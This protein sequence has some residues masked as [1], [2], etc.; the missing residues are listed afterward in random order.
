MP[1]KKRTVILDMKLTATLELVTY[2]TNTSL[3][4]IK[5]YAKT[6]IKKKNPVIF[7]TKLT[8]TLDFSTYTSLSLIKPYEKKKK[9]QLSLA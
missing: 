1:T 4:P 8:T 3:N 7:G 5:H 6:K 2:T 9:T